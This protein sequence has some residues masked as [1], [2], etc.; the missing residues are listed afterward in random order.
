MLLPN[1]TERTLRASCALAINLD[2]LLSCIKSRIATRDHGGDSV[3]SFLCVKVLYGDEAKVPIVH[4]ERIL[5]LRDQGVG[6]SLSIP[7]L[8]SPFVMLVAGLS[9]GR[10]RISEKI[11]L[12]YRVR[13]AGRG[14]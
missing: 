11:L 1:L 9:D 5:A 10:K 4:Y 13:E 3:V 14:L 6:L 2:T 12:I 8:L 7:M